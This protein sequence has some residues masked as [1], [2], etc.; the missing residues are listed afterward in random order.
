MSFADPEEGWAMN[1]FATARLFTQ[2]CGEAMKRYR[3][4]YN[5]EGRHTQSF[6]VKVCDYGVA[7][8]LVAGIVYSTYQDIG[9]RFKPSNAELLAAKHAKVTVETV[10]E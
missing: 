5:D 3:D 6:L 8:L 1:A 9:A 7:A 10:I 4:C 2:R